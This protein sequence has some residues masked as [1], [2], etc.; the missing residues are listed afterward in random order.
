MSQ[1]QDVF[2]LPAPRG[3]LCIKPHITYNNSVFCPLQLVLCFY[4]PGMDWLLEVHVFASV[5]TYNNSIF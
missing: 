1:V 3:A 4:V 2:A 5:A